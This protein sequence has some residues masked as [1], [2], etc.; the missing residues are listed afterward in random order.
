LIKLLNRQEK[1]WSE[2]LKSASFEYDCVCLDDYQL[3]EV[4]RIKDVLT[5]KLQRLRNF[6][7]MIEGGYYE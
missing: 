7:S 1:I 6:R 4:L 2:Q 5:A 3:E